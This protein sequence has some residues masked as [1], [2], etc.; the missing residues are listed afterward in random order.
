[1]VHQEENIVVTRLEEKHLSMGFLE[2]IG[3]LRP[4]GLSPDQASFILA[5]MPPNIHIFVAVES[6]SVIGCGTLVLEQKFIHGGGRV[7][8]IEDVAVLPGKRGLGVG[9]AIVR[10]L[11]EEAESSGCYKAI[12]DCDESMV[13]YYDNLGFNKSGTHMRMEIGGKP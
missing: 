2:T 3:S 5:S 11:V 7:A 13:E 9:K 1:M 12:L 10:R 4:T 6:G 8:H